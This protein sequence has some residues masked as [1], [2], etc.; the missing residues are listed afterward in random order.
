MS[1]RSAES[2]SEGLTGLMEIKFGVFSA[3]TFCSSTLYFFLSFF[4]LRLRGNF[5]RSSESSSSSSRP[6]MTPIFDTM[7]VTRKGRW[8]HKRPGLVI[9]FHKGERMW[10]T[11]CG[12]TSGSDALAFFIQS[13][14]LNA[15][16]WNNE[17]VLFLMIS[18][19]L[20]L[21]SWSLISAQWP[22][23]KCRH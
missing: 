4:Q 17:A 22:E 19:I 2:G 12:G 18:F 5:L 3:P 23:R 6:E 13:S 14:E 10:K 9:Q 11:F 20:L 21:F 1:N 8:L 7:R 16:N 15:K